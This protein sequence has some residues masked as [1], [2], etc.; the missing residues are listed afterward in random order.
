LLYKIHD[1]AV[2]FASLFFTL[3]IISLSLSLNHSSAGLLSCYSLFSFDFFSKSYFQ[4]RNPTSFIFKTSH[5][6]L[7]SC[8]N[9]N[10]SDT[11]AYSH[12]LYNGIHIRFH[13]LPANR[14]G[15]LCRYWPC[16]CS[17]WYADS[18]IP[19]IHILL[20]LVSPSLQQ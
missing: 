6:P 20:T 9:F 4:I 13:S 8:E 15:H 17:I 11:S 14:A 5:F 16:S 18:P 10:I 1:S 19:I 2:K 12:R 7:L 3:L